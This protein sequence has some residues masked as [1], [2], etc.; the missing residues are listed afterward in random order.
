MVWVIPFAGIVLS[1][2]HPVVYRSGM[3]D[4]QVREADHWVFG[5]RMLL[6]GVIGLEVWLILLLFRGRKSSSEKK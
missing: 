5:A 3:S 4:A 1:F 2:V 6:V